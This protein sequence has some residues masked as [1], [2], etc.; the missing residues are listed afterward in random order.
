MEE[1]KEGIEILQPLLLRKTAK[2]LMLVFI[3][4]SI[5]DV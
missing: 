1:E 3:Y 4:F 2:K 5:N